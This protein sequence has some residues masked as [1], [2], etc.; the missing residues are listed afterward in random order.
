S[1]HPAFSVDAALDRKSGRPKNPC[2]PGEHAC[3]S[4][5]SGMP[6]IAPME[7]PADSRSRTLPM[8]VPP[9]KDLMK[10]LS[11]ALAGSLLLT[12]TTLCLAAD[13]PQWRGPNRDGK[14]S[15]TGTIQNLEQTPPKLLW[16][17]E[18]MGRGYASVA[19]VDGRLYTTG[20]GDRGQKV[21]C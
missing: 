13:W 11:A 14:S 9:R 2:V 17:V 1:V 4:P 6:T 3:W 21:V 18:G 10:L 20:N 5:H 15:E 19:I 16:M 7:I 12:S 8:T